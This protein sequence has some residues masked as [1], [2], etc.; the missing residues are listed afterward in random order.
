M[1]RRTNARLAGAAFLLYIA[2]GI[3]SIALLGRATG[4]GDVAAKLASILQHATLVR[5]LGLMGWLMF[6]YA[7]VLAVTLWAL[8]RDED[9]HVAMLAMC[10]R[11][12]EGVLNA[13]V[14]I[15]TLQLIPVATAAAGG[16]N[17][18]ATAMGGLLLNDGN[19]SFLIGS[20]TFALG[21]TLFA[22]LL[23]RARSIPRALAWLGVVS[24]LL[25]LV[26]LP[27]RTLAWLPSQPAQLMWIPVA[28]F[29]VVF[30]LWLLI[31]GVAAP[32]HA[33]PADSQDRL[34]DGTRVREA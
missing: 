24:S 11:L 29:E 16:S 23:L 32:A 15:Q 31:K 8:T 14:A 10:C 13:M 12:T 18:A 28:L 9:P 22:W 3:F 34:S 2:T 21:S 30:A 20:T 1:T 26:G 7:I 19:A 33:P 4:S 27:L 5:A 17:P 6:V 25:I